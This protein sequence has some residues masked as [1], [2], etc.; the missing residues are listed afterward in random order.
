MVGELRAHRCRP[1]ANGWKR[2]DERPKTFRV[3][4]PQCADMP[5]RRLTT[6]CRGLEVW[7]HDDHGRVVCE[8]R[9]GYQP[10]VRVDPR[11]ADGNFQALV[12]PEP[13]A[14]QVAVGKAARHDHG[15]RAT[16]PFSEAPSTRPAARSNARS[17]MVWVSVTL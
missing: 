16:E 14:W 3:A 10:Y 12:K 9:K 17:T 1:S 7:R 2:L 8:K 13:A 6:R 4:F 5:T 11:P 15:H